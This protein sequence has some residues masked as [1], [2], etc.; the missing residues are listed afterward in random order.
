[1]RGLTP[2]RHRGLTFLAHRRIVTAIT[3]AVACAAPSLPAQRLL[4]PPSDSALRVRVEDYMRRLESLGFNGAILIRRNG[5]TVFE[6]AYGWADRGT[7]IRA[8]S[9]TVWNIGSITK[10]FTAAAIL[11]LEET[12]KL[13]TTDSIARFFPEAPTDKRGIT[14]HQLLTHT[15]GFESDYS[16]TDYEPT[17]REE[18][19]R[20]MFAAPLRSAPGT[21][22]HY[23]NAGYSLLAAIIESVTAQEYEPALQRLV[24]RPIGMAQTGYKAPGWPAS[25]IAHGYQDSRDWGTI[26]SRIG[27]DGAPYW[28]LRG[29]GGLHTT[30]D[31]MARWD[32]ALTDRR[33]LTDS[34]RRKFTTGYVNEGPEGR[35]KYAYGWAVM[36]TSRNTRLV[37]H[38]GGNGIYVA[39]LLRFVDDRV[40]LF[41]ASSV[42]SLT[43]TP[44]ARVVSQILFSQPYDVPPMRALLAPEQLA[45]FP[46]VWQFGDGSRLRIQIQDGRVF[47][48]PTGQQAFQLLATGDTVVTADVAALNRRAQSIVNSLVQGDIGP[49]RTALGPQGPDSATVATEEAGL[50]ARRAATFGTLQ[51]V[52][53]L[54][55]IRTASGALRTTVRLNYSGGG[56]TNLYTWN[57]QGVITDVGARPWQP[58]ELTPSA[59]GLLRTFDP[60]TGMGARFSAD[61]LG[62]TVQGAATSI[63]LRRSR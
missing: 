23:S 30:L 15:A 37:T 8:D 6:R 33:L 20:R 38:N 7:G 2:P 22:F 21:T 29:N 51:S 55:T 53:V 58:I 40:T 25:R 16:P 9:L 1:M 62:L 26:I 27:M 3:F 46:G 43:A 61:A 57:A 45:D 54:G 10:Q 4:P 56:A 32:G 36:Q 5:K 31:D 19:V 35:S 39:E 60:G 34:S 59:D 48:E 41:I 52:E 17:T 18:Y 49:L 14:I 11:R 12:R 13:R 44:A 28:A 50:L 47:A 42:S 24:L 63:Q